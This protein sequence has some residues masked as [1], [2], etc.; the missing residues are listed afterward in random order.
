MKLFNF[1][2]SEQD[3]MRQYEGLKSLDCIKA[4]LKRAVFC[5]SIKGSAVSK[6][7]I[8][9]ETPPQPAKPSSVIAQVWS[10]ISKQT[11]PYQLSAI[12]TVMLGKVKDNVTLLQGPPGKFQSSNVI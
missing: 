2:T 1:F 7:S 4:N 12:E 9:S 11:N 6:K 8:T 5:N 10:M 3:M